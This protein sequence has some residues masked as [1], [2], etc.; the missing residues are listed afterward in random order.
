M[1]WLLLFLFIGT[2]ALGALLNRGHG[3]KASGLG[4]FT[5]PTADATRVI[6]VVWGTCK[7]TGPN[8]IWY[9][10]LRVKAIKQGQFFGL[11][12]SSTV[13]Y[14][15][16]LGMWLGLCHGAVDD[17][18]GLGFGTHPND[19]A[20][21]FN[22]KTLLNGDH[23]RINV[24]QPNLYGGEKQEGG[25][26]G[27]F[28]FYL[29]LNPQGSNDY[30]TNKLSLLG[31]GS[32]G[33]AFVP[34]FTGAGNGTIGTLQETAATVSETIT[35][36][37][38][39]QTH[40]TVSG[41][42]SGA[43]GS[44]TTGNTFAC[45]VC[46]FKITVGSNPFQ[47]GDRFQFN[48]VPLTAGGAP[49]YPGLCHMVLR[50]MYLGTSNYLKNLSPI[51][52][53]THACDF[54]GLGTASD[55][56]GDA[57]PANMLYECMTN[58]VW[59]QGRPA[60]L[61]NTASFVAA[62]TRLAAEGAGLTLGMSM[63]LDNPQQLDQVIS[64]ILSHIDGAIYTDPQTG[65]WTLTLA[66]FD[67]DPATLLTFD[68]TNIIGT[69]EFSRPSWEETLNQIYVTY[70]ERATFTERNVKADETAN[71]ATTGAVQEST[72]RFTGFSNAAS[73]QFVC[74]RELKQHSYPLAQINLMVNR[75]GWALRIGQT[76]K[77]TFAAHGVSNLICRITSINYGALEKGEIKITAVEDIYNL[78]FAAYAPPNPTSWVNPMGQPQAPLAEV[79]IEAPYYYV[80]D[81]REVM[82]GAV[83]ADSTSTG[84]ELW[85]DAGAGYAKLNVFANGFTPSGVLLNDYLRTTA[86]QDAIGFIITG[87]VDMDDVINTDAAGLATGNIV[88]LI[89]S[90]LLSVQTVTDNL[91]GTLTVTGV[92]RGVMDTVPADH[93][94]GARVYFITNGSFNQA[95]TSPLTA[96]ITARAYKMLPVNFLNTVSLASVTAVT[97]STVTRTPKPYPPGNVQVS[98]RFWLASLDGDAA[99]TLSHRNRVSQRAALRLVPQ[100]DTNT[101][102]VTQEGNYTIDVLVGGVVKQTQAAQTGV[103]PYTYTALQRFL[104][105]SDGTA[106][107]QFR[108]TSINGAFQSVRTTDAFT[109]TGFGLTFGQF[110][111]GQNG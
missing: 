64:D 96:D 34:T 4:D 35:V 12:G 24:N 20:V 109:M 33:V 15:Y 36:L 57:N 65:L 17:I 56:N 82:V 23:Y 26:A 18:V 105:N 75:T 53:R 19:K 51:V 80:G 8:V 91:D 45:A 106:L 97:L 73:A 108:I 49:A 27:D 41:S 110:L 6:P 85:S 22:T 32:G 30:I 54:L 52:R 67:Y 44:G 81:N 60:A 84:Y 58:T 62:G 79:A 92:W 21:T 87:P 10:D 69:P 39:G 50:Q 77:Y 29:G 59:G 103:G 43:L 1:F 5:A 95:Y 104:D 89:D 37:F 78:G 72:L 61:F 66:R 102:G 88:A 40:F 63:T 16:F 31:V 86:A 94:A 98:G 28:D 7:L 47:A 99:L 3:I 70:L 9:G 101:A 90:E 107:V 13:G 48:T 68:Q 14:K 25:I 2:T 71:F 111:G 46:S 42:V 93:F 11:L 38:T 55:I 83:R 74:M 100:D 76:F